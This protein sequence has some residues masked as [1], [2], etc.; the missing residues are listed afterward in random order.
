M[1]FHLIIMILH[2]FGAGLLIGIV[3]LSVFAVFKPPLSSRSM[4]RLS[5]V[6]KFGM[7]TS[8]WLFAT[9]FF[10][11]Y[12]DWDEF[13]SS[14]VFWIKMS[15][16]IVEGTLASLLINKQVKLSEAQTANGGTV[17]SGALRMSLVIQAALILAIA[18][19]GVVLV[20]GGSE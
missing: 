9:G 10:L 12:Q 15:L 14:R 19:L 5:F 2:V 17:Q 6:G 13:R 18:A 7:W 20:S 4:D 3:F 11:A 8:V 1:S 16:Y